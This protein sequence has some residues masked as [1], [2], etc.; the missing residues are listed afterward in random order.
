M[1]VF[2]NVLASLALQFANEASV[3]LGGVANS[4]YA[5]IAQALHIAFDTQNNRHL[6]F[7][8]YYTVNR[9]VGGA[10]VIMLGYPIQAPGFSLGNINQKTKTK[11]KKQA[12]KNILHKFAF[13]RTTASQMMPPKT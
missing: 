6:P 11:N 4:T 5:A 10:E 2:T 12:Q 1:Q 3:A 13:R 7:D 9:S 8:D